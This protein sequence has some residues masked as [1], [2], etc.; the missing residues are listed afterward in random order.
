MERKYVSMESFFSERSQVLKN[1]VTIR[2]R[3]IMATVMGA[4]SLLLTDAAYS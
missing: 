3:R 1:S 2:P 4:V